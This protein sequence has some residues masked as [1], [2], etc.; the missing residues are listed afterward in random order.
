MDVVEESWRIV[1]PILDLTDQP[2]PY[3]PGTWGPAEADKAA[4]Y[5]RWHPL[6]VTA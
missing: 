2:L 4:L 1:A 3:A 6:E 5:G